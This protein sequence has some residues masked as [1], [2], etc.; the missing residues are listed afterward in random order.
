MLNWTESLKELEYD[1]LTSVGGGDK[2]DSTN[3]MI[4]TQF[5]HILIYNQGYRIG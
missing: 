1:L 3:Q 2:K 4:R 5:C